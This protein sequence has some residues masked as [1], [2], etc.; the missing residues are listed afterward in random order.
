MKIINNLNSLFKKP[1]AKRFFYS[2]NLLLNKSTTKIYQLPKDTVQLYSPSQSK[3]K[4]IK[5]KLTN[6]T[7]YSKNMADIEIN[8]SK[9][10]KIVL[11]KVESILKYKQKAMVAEYN[12]NRNGTIY[13]SKIN[14]KTGDI[15]RKPMK[16]NIMSSFDGKYQTTFHFMKP[17]LSKELGYVSIIDLKMQG[18]Q[19]GLKNPPPQITVDYLE[20]WNDQKYHGIGELADR[21]CIEYC[22]KK[23][24]PP[25]VVSYA[26]IGSHIA[27]Y[28]RGKR[29]FPL[30]KDSLT[31]NYFKENYNCTDLNKI[32]KTLLQKSNGRHVSIDN[33]GI[34][35]MYMPKK[36]IDKYVKIIEKEPLL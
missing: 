11:D 2:Q 6:G 30:E 15:V 3:L 26:D 36:L 1:I 9:P 28:K 32:I 29:F 27:H 8:L 18:L 5:I 10:C 25:A 16:V 20:N 13:V 35:K 7:T 17:D 23:G 31:Y 21:L 33:W 22:L 4:K 14:K 34:T 12:P 19:R 24:Y